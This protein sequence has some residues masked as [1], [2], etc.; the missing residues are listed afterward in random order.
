MT[1][2]LHARNASFP[3]DFAWLAALIVAGI[4][5]CGTHQG[6]DA[7]SS[8]GAGGETASPSS[9]AGGAGS[10]SSS[11]SSSSSSSGG[12]ACGAPTQTLAWT[13]SIAA[14]ASV[15]A[16]TDIAAGPTNDV[17]VADRSGANY[18]QRRWSS[19]GAFV[20]LHQDPIGAYAGALWTSNLV[21]D[22][23]NDAFYGMLLT[24]LPMGEKSGARLVFNRL[25]PA[26]TQLWSLSSTNA[27][28]TSSG[29]PRV[30]VF[31]AG[32]DSGGNL[33]GALATGSPSIFA[34]G[35]YCYSPS[36]SDLGISAQS[37]VTGLTAHDVVW[38]NQI[39]GLTLTRPLTEST[40]LGCGHLTVPAA[41]GMALAAFD[42]SGGCV[43]SKLL[44]LPK[45]A[46]KS[47]AFRLGADGSLA[48][49]VVY[50]GTIDFGGG[51]V[52]ST[53][54][55]SLGVARFGSAGQLLWAKSFGGAGS[56]FKLGS[57]GVNASGT[58]I[59][60]GGYAGP[61]DL[62]GGPLAASDD[63]FLAVFDTAGKLRWNRTV[64]VGSS[65]QLIAAAGPC[66]LV[67][68]TNS[69]SVDL[70]GGP[71]STV[72]PGQPASVGVAALSL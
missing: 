44:A 49:A 34:S 52:T 51:A 8:G 64:T 17:V 46:V 67:L 6:D 27:I 62:G 9:G 32:V 71:L 60:T 28:S 4:S 42:G 20:G 65:G 53:G 23:Q 36:G 58:L 21:V 3:G 41:G 69:P 57:L 50:T 33:H 29:P 38:P 45:A 12:N 2:D 5:S 16:L 19:A 24:G 1:C 35:V 47:Y 10:S 18:E 59:V 26:G 72:Q 25:S 37:A 56:R 7:S 55:S 68:A 22:A 54:T 30:N 15:L 39:M 70:G 31:N 13:A 63:T 61:I 43:W 11:A 14:T 40:N 48:L 66:A